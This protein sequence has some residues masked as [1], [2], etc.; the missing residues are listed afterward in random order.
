MPTFTKNQSFVGRLW[1]QPAA[2]IRSFFCLGATKASIARPSPI[3]KLPVELTEEIFSY[4][5]DDIPNLLTCSL[6]C[7]SWYKAT[8]RHLHYSLTTDDDSLAPTDKKR[9]WP[10]PLEKSYEL[11]LLPYVKRLQIRMWRRKAWFTPERLNETNLRYFLALENLQELG[12]DDLVLCKFM[13]DLPKYFGPLSQTL[14][15]LALR[16]PIGSSREI[17]YFIGFFP[18]LQDLKLHYPVL[19][20]EEENTLDTTPDP[21]SSPP[22]RGRLTLTLFTREQIVKD[23]ITLFGGLRFRHMDLFGVKCLPLLL[24]EC[25]ETLETLRLYPTDPYAASL[26]F[27]LSQN[28]ALQ[29]LETTAE[30]IVNAGNSAPE[31]LKTVLSSVASPGMLE[32][33]VIYRD[34]DLGGWAFCPTCK[35]DPICF[36]HGPRL[37]LD[38]FPSQLKVIREMHSAREFRLVLCVDVYGC[39]GDFGMRRLDAAVKREEA[40]GGFGYLK[41]SPVI[42]CERRTIRTRTKDYHA[43]ATSRWVLASAL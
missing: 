6:T 30:S 3:A 33:V 14:R 20:D 13:Q 21:L 35:P 38:D 1:C 41:C 17:V 34:C 40:N 39:M 15:F 42:T 43:G 12:I 31:F 37:D 2:G 19:R 10:G 11:N 27:D 22:L 9:W 26:R 4:F 24:E 29:T 23:M 5:A 32:V 16:Q 8:V 7:R 18:N 28:K 25:A 36:R